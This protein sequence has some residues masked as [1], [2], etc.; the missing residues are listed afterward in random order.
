MTMLA[1]LLRY[2]RTTGKALLTYSAATTMSTLLHVKKLKWLWIVY[3]II[4][5]MNDMFVLCFPCVKNNVL[6]RTILGLNTVLHT[7]CFFTLYYVAQFLWQL[8]QYH[9]MH[10]KPTYSNNCMCT[11]VP[12]HKGLIHLR[13]LALNAFTVQAI[14]ET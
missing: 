8:D 7:F 11:P 12:L 3:F 4:S 13:I 2:I 6:S 9:M 14:Y 10:I 5:Q 1:L